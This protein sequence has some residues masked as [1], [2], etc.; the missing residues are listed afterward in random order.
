MSRSN[1]LVINK[2]HVNQALTQYLRS[3][4]FIHDDEEVH[5]FKKSPEGLEIK[6]KD[7]D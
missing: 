7:A 4:S 5:S 3:L 2:E 6:V 1:I